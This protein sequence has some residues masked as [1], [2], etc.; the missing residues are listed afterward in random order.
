[1][2]LF[3][4]LNWNTKWKQYM[5]IVYQYCK[6]ESSSEYTIPKYRPTLWLGVLAN[7]FNVSQKHTAAMYL[8]WKPVS[9]WTFWLYPNLFN[10]QYWPSVNTLH[11]FQ[12]PA[13]ILWINI[14]GT[15]SNIIFPMHHHHMAWGRP[16]RTFS[17]T[18]SITTHTTICQSTSI[19]LA[20]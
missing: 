13:A 14:P 19:L 8:A 6:Y 17:G 12:H 3:F 11:S 16:R 7:V 2:G 18:A 20:D 1:M 4:S 9:R 5:C 15:N 10:I